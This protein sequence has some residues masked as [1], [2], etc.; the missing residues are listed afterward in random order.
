MKLKFTI[1]IQKEDDNYVARCLE[2]DVSSHGKTIELA[3]ANIREALELYCE[4]PEDLPVITDTYITNIEI[5][6]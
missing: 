6:V 4:D 1:I 3:M 2:N 5:A